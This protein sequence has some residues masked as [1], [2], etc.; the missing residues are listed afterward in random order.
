MALGVSFFNFA[1]AIKLNAPLIAKVIPIASN[2]RNCPLPERKRPIM[3]G[4]K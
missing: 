2:P 4:P 3:S 1:P